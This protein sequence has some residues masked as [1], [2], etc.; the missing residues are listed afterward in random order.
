MLDHMGPDANADGGG[1]CTPTSTARWHH[2]QDGRP[3]AFQP[4]PLRHAPASKRHPSPPR[5]THSLTHSHTHT[6]SHNRAHRYRRA[7]DGHPRHAL[8]RRGRA[9]RPRRDLGGSRQVQLSV[10]LH[11]ALA[12]L[13]ARE[14]SHARLQWGQSDAVDASHHASQSQHVQNQRTTSRAAKRAKLCVFRSPLSAFAC[15]QRSPLSRIASLVALRPDSRGVIRI[16]ARL[17]RSPDKRNRSVQMIRA[18]CEQ[19]HVRPHGP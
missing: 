3:T 18:K 15:T 11:L 6:H 4:N 16:T 9:S 1:T 14:R 7:R 13:P 8:R 10:Q 17:T 5:V 12:E 2:Q 19:A